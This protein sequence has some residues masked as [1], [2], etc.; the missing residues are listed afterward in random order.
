[1]WDLATLQPRGAPLRWPGRLVRSLAW[2]PDGQALAVGGDWLAGA[3]GPPGEG[4]FALILEVASG[5]L[6]RPEFSPGEAVTAVAFHP[7]GTRLATASRNRWVH[8][9][10]VQTGRVLPRALEHR[11]PVHSLS[12]SKDGRALAT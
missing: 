1:L 12:F 6:R 11:L 9:W 10:D 8:F 7:D 4:G 2:A 3:D 5:K